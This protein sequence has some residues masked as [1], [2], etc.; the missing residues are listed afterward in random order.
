[1]SSTT[2][3]IVA[4]D[5]VQRVRQ[6][7]IAGDLM[8][9]GVFPVHTK[10]QNPDEPC[11]EI[12]ETRG[13]HRVEAMLYALDRIN[14]QKDFLRGYKLGALILD[15][16]SNPAYALNQSL[17]FVRDMIGSSDASDY[18]CSD[19]SDP[20]TRSASKKKNVVAVVGA[21]YS[22]VTVQVAN[23]LR[24][25]RIV[26]VSPAS[27]NAD[28]SDKSRFEYFART[29]PSDDYQAMAMVEI[30]VRFKWTYVSLVY[31]AD[32]YGELGADAFKKEAR[33]KG[34][35]I[36]IEERI[37][38][39][40]ESFVESIDN[41]VKK[42]QPDKKVGARVVVLFVGTEYVP[43][44][45]KHTA[46]RMKLSAG[47]SKKEDYMVRS[48]LFGRLAS[49]SWD[50]NNEKYM[51][52]HNRLAAQGALVL[53]LASQK[54]PSFDE[55]L[56]SL[57]PGSEKFERNKWL[58]ELWISKYKCS[59][60]LPPEST[61]NRCEDAR[62]TS[63]NFHADD[64]VQF[65]IDAVY[66]IAHALQA[67]KSTVCPD[68]VIETSWISRY[69]KKPDICHA[70]QSIDGD[71]F[72]QKYLLKVQF[73][74]IVGKDFR[75]SPQGDGPASYT[76]L[77]YRPKSLDKKRR[78]S[79]DDDDPSDGSDYVEIGALILD[80]CS[81]PAYA[82]N[83]S[84]EFVRDMIGSSD[85]SDYVCSRFEYFARTVPSDDYQAMAMVEI[86][87]RFKWTYVSLVYSADEY[88]E[89]GAD[90]FKKEARKKGICI[91]IEERIQ[92]KKESFVESI[93]NLVK[94]LQPDKK[95]GA[96]VV[97]L[98]VGTEYVPELLKHTAERMKLSAG[99]SK[100][101]IIWLASESWDRNNEKYMIGHNRL[102]AQG[103]LVLML[104][105]QK[106]LLSLHPGSEKFERNKWLRELWISKYKCS[107]DLPPESTE[108]RCEDARQT[109]ENFHA[110]DKV[111]FVIDAVYAIAHALQA[112]KSTVCP[113]DVIETSWI[114]RYSKKPD[115]CHAM[116]SIDGDEF[117]QKYL[118]KVQFE[119]IVGKDFRFSPQGDG[120]ASY[121]ILTYRPKSLDKKRRVSEDDDDPSDGSDYVEIGHWSE[122]N[123]TIYEDELWWGKDQVPFS[124]CSLECRTGYRK[125]L[126]KDEQCCWACS[127]CEDY[128]F[129]I[130]ETHC[131]ACELGWW[132][133]EDRKGCYDLSITHL[134]HMRWSSL[135]SIVPAVFAVIGIIATL[136]V[137][138]I[139]IMYNET[140]VVKASGRE[141]SY[142]LLISMIMCYAMTF[143][144]LSRPNT[145]V[146][147]IKR[148][149]IGFAFSCLYAA[150]LVKTNRIARIFSQ[151]SLSAQRPLFIS[152]L[153]QVVMTSMLAG[154]QLIGSII[155]LFVVPP[156]SRH[157]YP[158]RDQVV[159]T[160]NVPD[161]HFLYSLAYDGI[162]IIA[163]TVYAVKTRKIQTTSLCISISMSAN[164]ALVCIFSPKL[165]I[166][167]FEK[168]KN[169]RKQEGENM[170]NKRSLGNCGSRLYGST[171]E[172]PNQ[173]T[174]L[175]GGDR[176]QSS[177]KFS[178]PTSTTSSAHDTFL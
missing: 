130:N 17:E 110:D 80:S 127:K 162:L 144:L 58:R 166:I 167:L 61:E 98:F 164:V 91:A 23:L 172:E 65:V 171:T 76:I 55:Y 2:T 13:V 40:K 66:A 133:T 47:Y 159:L 135:Y 3:A 148:T 116:Q 106:Y 170:L 39:K 30:A 49:E 174:A 42:L 4:D 84:L 121:T 64:K 147:A 109:S 33:K 35:C 82:L 62:Q 7:R 45:L 12:A 43:E 122:N 123:L 150:M 146:C 44:L 15:S 24:L 63:E 5:D 6:I 83:Q 10:S 31:S 57:H 8:L 54:V 93:D 72:Y 53:M 139:Y 138:V 114:S 157:D 21:S 136:F 20:L 177:R 38:N 108:N 125:Q 75:F 1:M 97:V 73:E 81:N 111:Q 48:H 16:C 28:L 117:Y 152:P 74:D 165:W 156:G 168:H 46:E 67:M 51:I 34:I 99:Y 96:R 175:L 27:T 59:F 104:A 70:M 151:A 155:W 36:A 143:V 9:G 158:T 14:A 32:E 71:E 160:C 37:Q 128:E 100:K 88:G 131:V 56:L 29:V 112:M 69:S 134:R 50:R 107:F 140:P 169:V 86:A 161:H 41:L 132:P 25:F 154:V 87:V 94:K 141:L 22:S 129:L 126:I 95:V 11:G 26:Q 173:Y 52:G 77:T 79:E 137:I 90:A 105:S 149:G 78:V 102:A 142:L 118:L 113:D 119:D 85:A 120:P 19:G 115:I 124:Q 89:L 103:A 153:S 60:D 145:V 92:N 101:K 163:C 68:D 178:H 176:K 18:V